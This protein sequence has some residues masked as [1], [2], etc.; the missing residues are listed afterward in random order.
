MSESLPTTEAEWAATPR[1]VALDPDAEDLR[2]AS[3]VSLSPCPFCGDKS[4]V[5]MGQ[6]QRVSGIYG[7]HVQCGNFRCNASVLHSARDREAARAG[8]VANWQRRVTQ[9]SGDA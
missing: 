1:P 8:A 3:T 2:L 4:P 5:A 6:F 7:Y 9:E